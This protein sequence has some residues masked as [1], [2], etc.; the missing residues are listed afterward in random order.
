MDGRCTAGAKNDDS[1]SV[2]QDQVTLSLLT[3]R[4]YVEPEK[5]RTPGPVTYFT[6]RKLGSGI[7]ERASLSGTPEV[8]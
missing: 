8:I 1:K 2:D 5:Q 4:R 7:E 3:T 6:D